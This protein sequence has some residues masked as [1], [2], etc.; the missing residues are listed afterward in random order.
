[1]DGCLAGGL[2]GPQANLVCPSACSAEAHTLCYGTQLTR[3]SGSRLLTIFAVRANSRIDLQSS[4]PFDARLCLIQSQRLPVRC[5][6]FNSSAC[7][8]TR[9]CELRSKKPQ[10]KLHLCQCFR[11]PD[12]LET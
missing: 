3:H 1:M 10:T 11:L 12:R 2:E 8:V 9:S 4:R 5:P 6:S 7:L